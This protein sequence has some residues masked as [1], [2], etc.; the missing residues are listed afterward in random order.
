MASSLTAC[1]PM[2]LPARDDSN[3]RRTPS[4]SRTSAGL[5]YEPPQAQANRSNH[6]GRGNPRLLRQS[7]SCSPRARD[8]RQ[9]SP[10]GHAEAWGLRSERRNHAQVDGLRRGAQAGRSRRPRPVP[11][12]ARPGGQP[13]PRLGGAGPCG[14]RHDG[15]QRKFFR[16]RASLDFLRRVRQESPS[17]DFQNVDGFLGAI[18]AE[19]KA[20]LNELRT[21]YDL[22][23]AF[24]LW[25]VIM[26]TRYNEHLAIEHAKRK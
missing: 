5:N 20:T 19:D 26:V 11:D 17:V 25:E 3:P 22:E 7:F 21:I 24:D 13:C 4:P 10:F 9:V 12:Y 18:L 6:A 15:V 2:A 16:E 14:N 1:P 23:D 8:H